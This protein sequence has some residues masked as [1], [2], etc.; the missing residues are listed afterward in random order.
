MRAIGKLARRLLVALIVVAV[1]GAG[2]A[3]LYLWQQANEGMERIARLAE[4]LAQLEWESVGGDVAGQFRVEGLSIKPRGVDDEIYLKRLTVRADNI[5]DVLDL[6]SRLR[7]GEIPTSMTMTVTGATVNVGGGAYR[8]LE[9]ATAGHWWGTPVDALGCGKVKDLNLEVLEALGHHSLKANAEFRLRLHEPTRRAALLLDVEIPGFASTTVDTVLSLGQTELP[10]N[11]ASTV[12]SMSPKISSL[13]IR[14]TDQGFNESRNYYCAAQLDVPV[15]EFIDRHL[16]AVRE[17]LS[18]H[19]PPPTASLLKRYRAFATYGGDLLLDLAPQK[20]V[21]LSDLYGLDRAQFIETMQP[22]LAIN[23]RTITDPPEAW[24][25]SSEAA[26]VKASTG[27]TEEKPARTSTKPAF[28]EVTVE[29]LATLVG[30]VARV[31]MHNGSRHEGIIREAT[32]LKVVLAKRMEGGEARFILDPQE[33][34]A[35]RVRQ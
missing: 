4:P 3:K 22:R 35:V 19:Q 24:I 15:P 23:G 32:P 9:T 33:I 14:Y 28:G 1:L 13:R 2:G 21:N 12:A 18:R 30:H 34:A 8:W 25:P 26:V 11:S 7:A 17:A 5:R 27:N 29:D 16:A 20:A 31:E 10:G 6:A